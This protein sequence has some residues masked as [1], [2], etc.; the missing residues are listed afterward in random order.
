MAFYHIAVKVDSRLRLPNL[1]A[2]CSGTM[3]VVHAQ[4]MMDTALAVSF[5]ERFRSE[6]DYRMM[7]SQFVVHEYSKVGSIWTLQGDY[8]AEPTGR[9]QWFS[10]ELRVPRGKPS[11]ASKDATFATEQVARDFVDRCKNKPQMASYRDTGWVL[12]PLA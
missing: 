12:I 6:P 10:A 7:P 4:A 2:N 8:T 3:T 11:Q 5:Y 9:T 1:Y